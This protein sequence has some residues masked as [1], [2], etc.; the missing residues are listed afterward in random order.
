MAKKDKQKKE[1]ELN[2]NDVQKRMDKYY[3]ARES[4]KKGK[5]LV[6]S[7]IGTSVFILLMLLIIVLKMNG[8]GKTIVFTTDDG[9]NISTSV[10]DSDEVNGTNVLDAIVDEVTD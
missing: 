10:A 2:L 4:E 3:K 1:G 6:L 9:G 7:L 5:A 8:V